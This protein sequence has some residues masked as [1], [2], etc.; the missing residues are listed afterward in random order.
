VPVLEIAR[1]HEIL[2]FEIAFIVVAEGID[3]GTGIFFAGRETLAHKIRRSPKTIRR[4]L[5]LLEE[6]GH[7]WR[8]PR[9][10]LGCVYRLTGTSP[11][12]GGER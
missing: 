9:E 12:V 4:C 3:N 6:R 2:G 5:K 1:D 8:N 11:I 10:G 7:L